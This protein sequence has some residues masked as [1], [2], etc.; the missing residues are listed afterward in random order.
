MTKWPAY[1]E[2]AEDYVVSTSTSMNDGKAVIQISLWTS[3]NQVLVN[4]TTVIGKLEDLDENM[5]HV[6]FG[7]SREEKA[8]R[9][10]ALEAAKWIRQHLP[11]PRVRV[12]ATSANI[13]EA[14]SIQS[15]KITTVQHETVLRKVGQERQWI[16]VILDNPD[17]SGEIGWI[18]G[19]LVE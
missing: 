11:F 1:A 3:K 12:K 8:I 16:K 17:N 19:E 5:L 13:M 10:A 6:M 7:A 15:V 9:A 18:Y 4:G 2:P 14:P